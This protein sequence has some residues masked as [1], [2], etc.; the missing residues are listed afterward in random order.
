[1]STRRMMFIKPLESSL[2]TRCIVLGY[3]RQDFDDALARWNSGHRPDDD[4]QAR[5]FQQFHDWQDRIRKG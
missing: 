5:I 4:T 1:M 2:R 3:S